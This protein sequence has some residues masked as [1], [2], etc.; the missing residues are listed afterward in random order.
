ME[1][2]LIDHYDS[3]SFNVLDWLEQGGLSVRRV[4]CDDDAA[5]RALTR[6][7][8]S[9]T[10]LVVSPGPRHPDAYPLTL[11]VLQRALGRTPILGICL[12]HQMLGRLSGAAIVPGKAPHHGSVRGISLTRDGTSLTP[13]APEAWRAAVYNSLVVDP[14]ALSP[15]WRVTARCDE[16]GEVM[17][18]ARVAPGAVAV[19]W[20]FH[21][22]SFMS[23]HGQ[24]LLAAWTR[25]ISSRLL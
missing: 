19:G 24:T 9:S 10:P 18:L 22:E 14:A 4:A 5:M 6:A 25:S 23:E 16:T 12:G 1:V 15:D 2:V 7:D 13:G 11:Q 17:G 21:P 8:G 3:F 20:Q